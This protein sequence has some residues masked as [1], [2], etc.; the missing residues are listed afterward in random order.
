MLAERM[1]SL[2]VTAGPAGS[3]SRYASCRI[4]Y[5]KGKKPHETLGC[6]RRHS[7]HCPD[8]GLLALKAHLAFMEAPGKVLM[9]LVTSVRPYAAQPDI[10]AARESAAACVQEG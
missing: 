10:D 6:A 8:G 5:R 2:P 3:A 1:R 4:A 9:T 7:R